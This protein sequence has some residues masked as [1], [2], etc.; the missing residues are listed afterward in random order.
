MGTVSGG[1]RL[2]E[3]GSWREGPKI[4]G[5]EGT[6]FSPD[7]KILAVEAGNGV[8]RLVNPNTGIEYASL[9]DPH[10]DRA[11]RMTFSPDGTQ[12]IAT[13]G[14]SQSIH[15][16]DLRAIREQLAKLGLD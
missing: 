10:Q 5:G 13:N 12:L 11:G 6:D 9:E 16:W 3:V 7:G 2:W 15:V 14:D 4:G 1:Y 8:I